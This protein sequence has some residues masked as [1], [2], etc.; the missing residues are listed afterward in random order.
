MGLH[1]FCQASQRLPFLPLP[2]PLCSTLHVDVPEYNSLFR[3]DAVNVVP[4]N[5]TREYFVV[6]LD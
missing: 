3:S 4:L 6:H 2:L 1:L 5:E